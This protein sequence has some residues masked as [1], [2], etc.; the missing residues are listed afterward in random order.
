MIIFFICV[1]TGIEGRT[2]LL[3]FILIVFLSI[4]LGG[5]APGDFT[6]CWLSDG[7]SM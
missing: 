5:L 3:M 1:P 4:F 6:G 2:P 7:V